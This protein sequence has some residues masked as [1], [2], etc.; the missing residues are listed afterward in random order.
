M[1]YSGMSDTPQSSCTRRTRAERPV[2]LRYGGRKRDHHA[3]DTMVRII[4][5]RPV[6][7]RSRSDV[8]ETKAP[9]MIAPSISHMSSLDPW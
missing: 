6:Q 9:S 5:D 7:H 3:E 1:A 2:A 4:T 8:L